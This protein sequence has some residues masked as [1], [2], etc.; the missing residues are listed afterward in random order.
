MLTRQCHFSYV[1]FFIAAFC[2]STL[3]AE[4]FAKTES[5]MGTEISVTLWHPNTAEGNEAVTSVMAEM[6]R[7]DQRFSP[8]I[9]TSELALVNKNAFSKK[10]N[11]SLELTALIDKSLYYN[12]VTQGAF[13]ITFAS[14]ARYYD[15]RNK[16]APTDAQ[17][18]IAQKGF[19]SHY[20]LFDKTHRTLKFAND[21]VQ[22]DL[23]GIAKGYAVD[24]A[25]S[26]LA[27]AGIKHATVSAGGDSRVLGDKLGAPWL[28]GIKNPRIS[29]D[30]DPRVVI[31]VP[32]VDS[33]IS[34]SGDYERY[35]ID[36]KSGERIHHII[37]PKTGKSASDVISV[38]IIGPH[39]IDTDALST[40]VFIM[41][42]EKGLGLINGL[43]DFDA[44]VIDA[45]GKVHYSAGLEDP[46]AT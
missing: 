32:L 7:I 6:H 25:V 5:I 19:N 35:F 38:S 14:V 11:L 12:K 31:K 3:H 37:N 44:I 43:P 39:G 8:Y 13:D 28:I 17:T 21:Y 29:D 46:T 2:C 23:G 20:L 26:I 36:P 15:Y 18:N 41:G 33:A 27:A 9:E 42:V 16:I 22:I 24:R 1:M 10:I 34:T 30:S 40:S 4:W 45:L